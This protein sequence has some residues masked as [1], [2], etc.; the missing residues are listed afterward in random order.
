MFQKL[1]LTNNVFY[2]EIIEENFDLRKKSL[3][4]YYRGH[5]QDTKYIDREDKFLLNKLNRNLEIKKNLDSIKNESVMIHIRREKYENKIIG[6]E[7]YEN[8]LKRLEKKYHN[9]ELNLFTDDE[10]I[11]EQLYFKESLN[12]INFTKDENYNKIKTFSKMLNNKHFVIA[13]ST[14]SYMA[15]LLGA[16]EDSTVIMP[17]PWMKNMNYNLSLNSWIEINCKFEL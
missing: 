15:A 11:V 2:Q 8:A 5:W 4:S 6:I 1:K 17:K 10:S 13:N 9:L 12:S 7:Y 16:E 3:I 14:F